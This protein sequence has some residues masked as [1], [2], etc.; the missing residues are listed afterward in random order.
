MIDLSSVLVIHVTGYFVLI[1]VLLGC[2]SNKHDAKFVFTDFQ[3]HTGWDSNFVSWSVSLL[4]AL[5]AFFS[6]DSASHFSEEIPRANV[7]V[8]RASK[9]LTLK[10]QT[11]A[12]LTLFYS[13]SP[14]RGQLSH[15]FPFYHC[16]TLLHW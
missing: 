9:S 2:S 11:H 1:G 4:A 14:G 12:W 16:G 3:N 10:I 6:L 5:Y 7:F 8:P 13:V 15:D